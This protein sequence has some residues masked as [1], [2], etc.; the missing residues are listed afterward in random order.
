MNSDVSSSP[1]DS[2]Q[3]KLTGPAANFPFAAVR[4]TIRSPAVKRTGPT[5]VKTKQTALVAL[6]TRPLVNCTDYRWR[7]LFEHAD[8][9]SDGAIRAESVGSS[10]YGFTSILLKDRTH[11]GGYEDAERVTLLQM[12]SVDPHAR[13][14][15]VRIACLDAQLRARTALASI[16]AEFTAQ[17]EPRGIRIAVEVEAAV[18]SETGQ[19]SAHS[20]TN[21][22]G[23]R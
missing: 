22:R 7:E 5:V 9:V 21:R 13:I 10:Y 20:G 12:L 3:V 1:I 16:H 19:R 23:K 11:G 4:P 14:R 8:V 15:A 6:R 2:G 17:L 18:I